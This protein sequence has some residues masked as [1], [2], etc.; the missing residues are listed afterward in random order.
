MIHF[1]DKSLFFKNFISLKTEFQIF[2][3]GLYLL[4]LNQTT[5]RFTSIK[6]IH[7]SNS[8]GKTGIHWLDV[9][10][11]AILIINALTCC[12]LYQPIMYFCKCYHMPNG[13]SPWRVRDLLFR[14]DTWAGW[15]WMRLYIY[16]L[17]WYNYSPLIYL[18][19]RDMFTRSPL[20][21][22]SPCVLAGSALRKVKKILPKL[23]CA[24]SLSATR[25]TR[26]PVFTL[27]KDVLC[28]FFLLTLSFITNKSRHY[29][30]WG[31]LLILFMCILF[32]TNNTHW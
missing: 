5:K 32:W 31:I 16:R 20:P 28:I 21:A 10:F 25:I 2:I 19:S 24:M 14:S 17:C 22:G 13:C 27:P 18:S 11:I 26:S 29:S 4:Y 30:L 1:L 12:Q 3:S 8:Y 15:L 23:T 6:M 7:F 9:P